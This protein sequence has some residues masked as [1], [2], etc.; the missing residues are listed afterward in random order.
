MKLST[1]LSDIT[2][3]KIVNDVEVVALTEDSRRVVTGSVFFAK[4]FTKAD[5][6]NH[7]AEAAKRGASAIVSHLTEIP[8]VDIQ[9]ITVADVS[10]SLALATARFFGMPT[11]KFFLCGVTG[12]NG[13]TTI[14]YLLEKIWS[15]QKSGVIGTVNV[16]VA[17][18]IFDATHTTPDSVALNGFFSE[19][20][21]VGVDSVAIEVSSHALTQKRAHG[22]AFN[23]AVFTN[24]TQDHLDYHE[25]MEDYFV[26]KKILFTELLAASPKQNKVAVI[27]LDDEYGQ[28]LATDLGAMKNIAVLTF[29]TKN[30]QA[31]LSINKAQYLI[32]G[33]E[34][35]LLFHGEKL[36]LKT[37]LIGEHNLRN[38]MAAFLVAQSQGKKN[39]LDLLKDV[40]VPGRLE[41]VGNSNFFVDYAHTP[42][43]LDNVLKALR[44]IMTKDSTAGRLWVVFGC[45]GDRDRKKRPLMGEIAA[46]L[47]DVVVVTSDNPRTEVAKDIVTEIL[48]GVVKGLKAYNGDKGYMIEVDRRTALMLAVE[49]AGPNDVVLVA[50]KGHEDYQIIGTE[51]IHFDDREEIAKFLC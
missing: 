6:A 37:N 31:H 13:K 43:A 4:S 14:T 39:A 22:C 8:G 32:S 10:L 34:A 48:P 44:E 3:S 38:I 41:R 47:A 35:E 16:R 17:G 36:T 5:G 28:R 45:G 49:E 18:K 2:H 46:S 42:D 24:L 12:T 30:P 27:N 40:R 23:A 9:V 51:K 25:N 7:I 19:M 21:K 15:P 26:A 1:L 20:V 50:G 33:T 29:S 11:Q